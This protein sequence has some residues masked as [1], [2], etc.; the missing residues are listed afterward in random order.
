MEKF[1]VSMC[2]YGKDNPE[3]FDAAIASI[4]NQT[5][6][7]AE[8]VLVVDGPIPREI[9]AVIEKYRA[10]LTDIV[11][12]PIYLEQNVGHGEARRIC[13]D[14]C[15]FELIALMDAD[16]LS[17]RDRFE[18]QL[19]YFD[20]NKDVSVV[21]GY[22]HEFIN[23]PINCV[24]KRI[25]P[26]DDVDIKEYMKKR[27]P[28]NQVTVMFRK[29]DIASVGGYIDWYC[30][31]DYYLW[32]RLALAGF[33]FGNIN[34]NL[35]DVRVGE[36]MY[37]RRGGIKYFMSEAKLQSFMLKNKIVSPVR[38]I[39]NILERLIIQVFIPNKLR[40]FIFQKLA[41]QK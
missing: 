24:G 8:I 9:D 37:S 1:S 16:D 33:K 12:R 27:C 7:P 17:V 3:Y 10:N 34:A 35:V 18:K 26:P 36:E 39:I 22:I 41:R 15:K 14:N 31:E 5:V 28:M 19:N 40:G 11:F 2:V 20:D 38:Y 6:K 21:G 30:E 29:N 13:F 25:V 23:A 4:V 32:I